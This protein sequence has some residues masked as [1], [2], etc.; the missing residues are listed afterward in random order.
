MNDIDLVIATPTAGTVRI[1]FAYSLVGVVS[2]LGANCLPSRPESTVSV[3]VDVA[4]SSVIHSNRETLVMR[5]I[6]NKRTHIMFLDDDMAFEPRVIDVLFSRRLPIVATNYM[7][8]TVE[9]DKFV[10]V[11]LDRRTRVSTLRN[12]TGLVPIAYTGFGVSLFEMAV[13]RS[14]PQPWFA[15][16]WIEDKK[17]YTTED[18]PCY[19]RLANAGFPCYLDQDASKLVT[20]LGGSS[21]KWD[22]YQAPKPTAQVLDLSTAQGVKHG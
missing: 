1:D 9:K 15:P 16:K 3:T 10:A 17:V 5:A 8:K 13:F 4:A 21:W 18:N 2:Y 6:E 20:H 22:E 14:T 12:S 11:G 7:I 19:E